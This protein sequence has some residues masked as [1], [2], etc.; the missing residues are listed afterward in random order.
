[1][2]GFT[3]AGALVLAGLLAAGCD[4]GRQERI[5]Q[6][7]APGMEAGPGDAQQLH[8]PVPDPAHDDTVVVDQ[9]LPPV[10]PDGQPPPPDQPPPAGRVPP[11]GS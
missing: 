5:E 10:T 1:M 9:T 3:T 4:D 6:E 7:A 11:G 8:P 2:R